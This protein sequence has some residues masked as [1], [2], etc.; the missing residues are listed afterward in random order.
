M[1]D[2]EHHDKDLRAA[3][4]ECAASPVMRHASSSGLA[5]QERGGPCAQ[6]IAASTHEKVAEIKHEFS[7]PVLA[8]G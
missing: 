3:S 1:P 5:R 6:A 4:E 8:G 7:T 2:T